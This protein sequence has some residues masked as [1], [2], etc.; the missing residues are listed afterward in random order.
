MS[1][2]Q[3]NR[4]RLYRAKEPIPTLAAML[5]AMPEGVTIAADVKDP[6]VM[7]STIEIARAAGRLADVMLWCRSAQA[8]RLAG[9]AAPECR[10]GYLHDSGNDRQ[11]FAY[12]KAAVALGAHIVS[13]HERATTPATVHAAK[14][15]GLAAY[16]WALTADTHRKLLDAGVDGIVTDYPGVLRK[17]IEGTVTV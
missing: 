2:Q 8:I 12:V 7:R 14:D 4:T 3:L 9:R 17:Q 16:A 1:E 10:L 15:A 11:T 13:I 5:A 6:R